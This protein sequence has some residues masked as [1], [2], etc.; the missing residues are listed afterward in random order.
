MMGLS[1]PRSGGAADVAQQ[2]DFFDRQHLAQI[3]QDD[4]VAIDLGHAVD[5][6]GANAGAEA[7]CRLTLLLSIWRTA[8]TESTTMPRTWLSVS[9]STSRMTTQVRREISVRPRP[10]RALRSITG[11]TAPRRLITPRM[12]SG[13]IGTVDVAVL[14]DLAHSQVPRQTVPCRG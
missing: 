4:E 2:G 5:E 10:N 7:G 12:K 3:E 8:L 13:I 11:T 9:D 14:D 6:V 1:V